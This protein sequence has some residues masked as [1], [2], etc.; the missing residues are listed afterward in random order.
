MKR[1][2]NL[3]LYKS[4]Q[5]ENFGEYLCKK[6]INELG[7]AYNS[8]SPIHPPRKK[9]DHI[10][11]GL[12]GYFNSQVYLKYFKNKIDRWYVWGTGVSKKRPNIERSLISKELLNDKCVVTMVRGLLSKEFQGLPDTILIGDPGYL[13][14][15][16]FE[17]PEEDKKNVF[18]QFYNDKIPKKIVGADVHLS[19]LLKINNFDD[20]FFNILRN[21]SNA[22]I[23]LTG[24][25]HIAIAAHS[26][27]VPWAVVPKE[28]VNSAMEWK[29]HDTLSG[30]NINPEEFKLCN[31]IDEGFQ[32]WESVKNKIKPITKEYQEQIIESFPFV[33]EEIQ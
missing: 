28:R 1:T 7:F 16:F 3:F 19:S 33:K 14:S 20:Q 10:V 18:V 13:T 12:G 15:Y 30:I 5:N 17:F 8:Y 21:I 11:T 29:W 32:W 4:G 23:V 6:I 25:M 26:Y 9:I 27:G 31:S 2:I 24:S 22:N